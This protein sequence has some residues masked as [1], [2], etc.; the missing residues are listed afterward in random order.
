VHLA[1]GLEG[2]RVSAQ[3]K[4]RGGNKKAKAPD[5]RNDAKLNN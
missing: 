4:I 5:G 2:E 3:S 1:L